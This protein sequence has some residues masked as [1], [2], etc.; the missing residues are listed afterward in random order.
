MIVIWIGLG[1]WGYSYV[2]YPALLQLLATRNRAT[3]AAEPLETWPLISIT[4]PAY[5]EAASIAETIEAVLA[6]DY[7]A[8]RRQILVISDASSDGTDEIVA[9]F[10][11]RGVELLR[12]PERRGKTAAENGARTVLT[13]DI[14]VN[15]DASVRIHPAAIKHLVAAFAD[16]KVGLAS[17]RDVSVARVDASANPGEGA[18]VGYEMWVRGLE[19]RVNGIVGASGSLYAIRASLHQYALPEALSRDFAAA[20]VARRFGYRAVS[21]PAAICFVPR[22]V[23]LRQEY[24]RKVRTMTR[25]L[26]TLFYMKD[27]LNPFQHG[28]FAWM[29]ASHKLCRWL[30]PWASLAI[31][32]ALAFEARRSSAARIML[33]AALFG[34]MAAM[35]GWLWPAGKKVPRL[36]AMPAFAVSGIVAGLNAWYRVFAGRLAPTW[37]P[38]RRGTTGS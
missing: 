21:V 27:L 20:L 17:S 15:T 7:P 24:N 29:L 18:Y 6:I 14:I 9:R 19:T 37:E 31:V 23:S 2:G 11:P 12:M 22:G 33:G 30:L 16:P 38:T 8:D 35:V 5:N 26:G 3:P 4:I 13:G 1:L 32:L 28:S 36:V 10:A 34:G 25:G